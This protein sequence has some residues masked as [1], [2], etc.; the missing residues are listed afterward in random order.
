[1]D[2][3]S[4]QAFLNLRAESVVT[5]LTDNPEGL[6]YKMAAV[7]SGK[8]FMMVYIPYGR[9]TTINTSKLSAAKLRG[10]WFNPRDGYAISL[11]EFDN[12]GSKEFVAVFYILKSGFTAHLSS[13]S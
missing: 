9:K 5:N 1:M 12:P 11:G 4:R 8:D 7:S 6:E 13:C 2:P 3:E 10:W